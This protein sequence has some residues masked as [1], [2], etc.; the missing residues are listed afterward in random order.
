MKESE[1]I[2]EKL[3]KWIIPSFLIVLVIWILSGVG[4][5]FYFSTWQ[6]RGT[7]GDMFGAINALFSGLAFLGVIITIYLQKRELE[8]QR[9]ELIETKNELQKSAIAQEN[10][11]KAL[12]SQVESS[13]IAAKVNALKYLIDNSSFDGLDSSKSYYEKKDLIDELKS[14]MRKLNDKLNDFQK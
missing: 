11:E 13:L 10:S 3:P 4:V 14:T 7:F 5:Y 12:R 8:Y 2:K 9:K 6:D 1:L